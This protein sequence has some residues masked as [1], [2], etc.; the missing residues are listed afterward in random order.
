M[1]AFSSENRFLNVSLLIVANMPESLATLTTRACGL[2]RGNSAL[3]T[4]SVPKKFILIVFSTSFA[5]EM[6]Y[7]YNDKTIFF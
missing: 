1:V 5:Y 6:S 4:F 7:F 3:H 2:N